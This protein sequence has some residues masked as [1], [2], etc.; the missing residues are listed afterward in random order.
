MCFCIKNYIG[1][2][3]EDLSSVK[4]LNSSGS[5][6]YRPFQGG[7]PGIGLIFCGFVVFTIGRSMLS[8]SLLFVLRICS[9]YQ[10][11]DSVVVYSDCY[12]S[13]AFCWPLTFCSFC[14]E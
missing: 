7:G 3:V 14:L 9:A 2:K 11:G 8:P 13:S 10:G 12:C 4:K 6:C 1:T 5:L